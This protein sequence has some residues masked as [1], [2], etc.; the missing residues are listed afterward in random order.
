MTPIMP[1]RASQVPYP[2]MDMDGNVL[3]IVLLANG[4]ETK[5]PPPPDSTDV[6]LAAT[7][8]H[9]HTPDGGLLAKCIA[10]STNK[11]AFISRTGKKYGT[12]QHLHGEIVLTTTTGKKTEIR[13]DVRK[14]GITMTSEKE[15]LATIDKTMPDFDQERP[16]VKIRISSLADVAVVICTFVCSE[17]L[18]PHT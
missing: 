16:Y 11:F 2:F 7:K 10:E 15:T 14:R 5:F 9:L 1:W 4:S 3:L 12:L 18:A 17:L 6:G 8:L 13:G